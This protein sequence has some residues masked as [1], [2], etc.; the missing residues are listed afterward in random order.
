MNDD[1]A[2]DE[3]KAFYFGDPNTEGTW[4]II[5]T[6]DN[7]SFQRLESGEWVFKLTINP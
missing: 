4:R 1:I 7:L 2:S 5:R 3:G 6:G